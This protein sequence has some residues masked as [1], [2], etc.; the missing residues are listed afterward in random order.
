[1]A[2]KRRIYGKHDHTPGWHVVFGLLWVGAA[3]VAYWLARTSVVGRS[4]ERSDSA[5]WRDLSQ[6]A[7]GQDPKCLEQLRNDTAAVIQGEGDIY[8]GTSALFTIVV[9]VC[10]VG[11]ARRFLAAVFK[12]DKL[13]AVPF[14]LWYGDRIAGFA[15]LGIVL[16]TLFMAQVW[17]NV[18]EYATAEFFVGVVLALVAIEPARDWIKNPWALLDAKDYKPAVAAVTGG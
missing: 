2:P 9:V 16:P 10:L 5:Y 15:F 13:Q 1:M 7:E 8:T 12:I 11:A 18:D 17:L 14:D 4:M 3:V 6:C